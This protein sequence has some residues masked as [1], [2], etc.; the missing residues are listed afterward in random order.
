MSG[1]RGQDHLSSIL[2]L[3]A[4]S[5]RPQHWSWQADADP[6][7]LP[8]LY[9]QAALTFHPVERHLNNLLPDS[10]LNYLTPWFRTAA[11]VL[12]ANDKGVTR[13]PDKVRVLPRGLRLQ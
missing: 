2:P 11:A 3:V 9:P 13:W 4:D 7:R 10:T 8:L 6:F 1:L 12:E 5:G